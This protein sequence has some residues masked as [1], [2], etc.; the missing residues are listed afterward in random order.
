MSFHSERVKMNHGNWNLNPMSNYAGLRYE[1]TS[2]VGHWNVPPYD[3]Q[4]HNFYAAGPSYGN[5]MIFQLSRQLQSDE[6][7][8]VVQALQQEPQVPSQKKHK[9]KS[10][11]DKWTNEE[12]SF[13]VDLWAEKHDCLE[14]KDMRKVWQEIRDEIEINFGKRK[15]V[16]KSQ[17]KIK[18]LIDKKGCKNLEQNSEWRPIKKSVFYDKID[19]VLETRD[20]VTLKHVVEVGARTDSPI[21]IPPSPSTDNSVAPGSSS[22]TPSPQ[23]GKSGRQGTSSAESSNAANRPSRARKERKRATKRRVPEDGEEEA[24]S[25][26]RSIES[27]EKQGEK[28]TKIMQ[29]L[30]QSRWHSSWALL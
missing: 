20:V 15:T 2:S 19:R 10:S 26:K 5:G 13:L 7:E 9:G 3:D 17:R 24:I 30:Q 14:S 6:A 25:L 23:P 18:Y 1:Q 11:N 12:Q 4:Y 16:E 27:I 21:P 28:L 22:G 8:V 29:R